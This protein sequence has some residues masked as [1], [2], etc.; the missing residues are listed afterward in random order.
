MRIAIALPPPGCSTSVD[1]VFAETL[2]A[3]AIHH[4]LVYPDPG[5]S[6]APRAMRIAA[7]RSLLASCDAIVGMVEPDFLEARTALDEPPNYVCLLMGDMPRGATTLRM[8]HA[9]MNVAD[10]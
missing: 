4:Q 8:T 7:L 5:V 1:H 10:T 2:A 6:Y 3:L 9:Q